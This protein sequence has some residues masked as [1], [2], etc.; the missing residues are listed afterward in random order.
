MKKLLLLLATGVSAMAAAQT[1]ESAFMDTKALGVADAEGNA[2]TKT[3]AA[4]TVFCQSASVT[5]SA[6]ADCDYKQVAMTADNDSVKA[7]AIDGVVYN[8]SSQP[9]AQG[10]TNPGP[11][12][13]ISADGAQT[14]G[15]VYKFDVKADGFLYV[16]CK[17]TGNK[18][19]WVWEDIST[20]ATS[21]LIG[22]NLVAYK[23]GAEG[24]EY[25]YK[26]PGTADFNVFAQNGVVQVANADNYV[27]ISWKRT[28]VKY[29]D[30]P[31]VTIPDGKKSSDKV[32]WTRYNEE[33][34]VKAAVDEYVAGKGLTIPEQD[35]SKGLKDGDNI[36]L[37]AENTGST[38]ATPADVCKAIGAGDDWGSANAVGV[39]AFPV[40]AESETY[41]VNACG[42]KVTCNGF[43]FVPGATTIGK[44][45]KSAKQAAIKNITMDDLDSD[46]PVYNLQ[47][48]RVSKNYKGVCI[49]GGKKFVVK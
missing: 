24:K 11:S 46:A 37:A 14:T 43:V 25:A 9:G 12:T 29:E 20:P 10:Q 21:S 5:M 38:L 44:V 41:T 28:Y 34:D 2:V 18:T 47:G 42:S 17:L 40:Y 22:Y 45:S 8:M 23:T 49:Q 6:L 39:I 35:A 19:Y 4:G 1:Q 26:L 16:F 13:T 30:V 36:V 7:I 15:A 27:A 32:T 33:A 31:S 48:Q 3:I